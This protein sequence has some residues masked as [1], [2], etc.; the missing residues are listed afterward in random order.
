MVQVSP[1]SPKTSSYS[2]LRAGSLVPSGSHPNFSIATFF[3]CS[4]LFVRMFHRLL[5][6]A[7]FSTTAS[8]THRPPEFLTWAN[9]GEQLAGF[10]FKA[11]THSSSLRIHLTDRANCLHILLT[12]IRGYKPLLPRP[13]FPL[14]ADSVILSFRL[15]AAPPPALLSSLKYA[16]YPCVLSFLS[17]VADVDLSSFFLLF[18]SSFPFSISI[19]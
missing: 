17:C 1:L 3:V 7:F 11:C 12:T 4:V 6:R 8:R 14:V 19:L 5:H 10:V 2:Y 15:G 9:R 18:F 16:H 13:C